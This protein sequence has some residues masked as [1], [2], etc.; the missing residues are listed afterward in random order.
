MSELDDLV[1]ALIGHAG[2]MPYQLLRVALREL[3]RHPVAERAVHDVFASML[4]QP[5]RPCARR[6]AVR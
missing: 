1:D 5:D 6:R 3:R 4:P 2:V